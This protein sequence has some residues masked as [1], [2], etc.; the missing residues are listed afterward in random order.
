MHTANPGPEGPRA[1]RHVLCVYPYRKEL[2]SASFVPPLGLEIIARVIAP[3]ADE[4]E[5]VDLR[6]DTEKVATDYLRD[7]TDMVCF[8]INW[9]RD[10][11]I[12]RDEVR[13]MPAGMLT[14]LGGR[15]VTEDPGVFMDELPNVD[16]IIRG[17]G[18]ETIAEYCQGKP[19]EEIEGLSYRAGGEVVHNATREY[20]DIH[21]EI[22]PDRKLRKY[23]YELEVEQISLGLGFDTLS[24]SRGCP[25][26]CKFC[27]FS[28]NP[29]GGKRKWTARSPEAVV[30]EL[31]GIEAPIVA[32]VDDLF[33]HDMKRVERICDLIIQRGIRKKFIINA[34][35]EIARHPAVLRK[36][37]RA[38]FMMLLLGIES[39]HDKT[40][41][42]MGK[43]F[44]TAQIRK[45]FD[46]LRDR[47]ML[48][49]GYFILGNIGESAEE[50]SQIVPFAHELGVD[51]L[52]LT[53]LRDSPY[54]G[55]DDLVAA[56]PDYHFAA[57][58]KIYSDHCSIKELRQLRRKLYREFYNLKQV[59]RVTRKG[60]SFGVGEFVPGLLRRLPIFGT[61]LIRHYLQRAKRH[62]QKKRR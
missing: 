30:D 57:S 4:I 53:M 19:L 38:G 21:D 1:F 23:K 55:L 41:K 59:I 25:F 22:Y 49:H 13:S 44:T 51:T 32:F 45:Y 18:E 60:A 36:M 31:E 34:R 54:S 6:K 62:R 28:R 5:I 17:D 29:W 12:W 42:S 61:R 7:D 37:E 52:A 58:G 39:A 48:L 16:V 43:G 40:L 11:E 15:H 8:S 9:D 2:G 46:V 56:N 50:I 10:A 26:N 3:F 20:G 47:P 24:A 33:T 14:V 27:S 35:L